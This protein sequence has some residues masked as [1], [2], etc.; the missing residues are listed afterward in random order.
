VKVELFPLTVGELS[1]PMPVPPV[2]GVNGALSWH[3]VQLTAPFGAPPTELPATVAVSPHGLP[4]AVVLGG[5]TVVV[6]PGVAGVT[7]KHS[8]E[9]A[10]PETLSSEPV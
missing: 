6:N 3:S 10:V 7:V 8:A 9:S 1:E 2:Q 5:S 4:T